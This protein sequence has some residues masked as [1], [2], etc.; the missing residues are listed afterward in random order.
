M[1]SRSRASGAVS[2]T[3]PARRPR[4]HLDAEVEGR[5]TLAI[6]N[7]DRE[8]VAEAIADLLVESFTTTRPGHADPE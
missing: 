4:H 3:A 8:F 2:V 5:P 6:Q 1:A 7:E